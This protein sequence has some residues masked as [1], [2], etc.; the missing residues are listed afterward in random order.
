MN[1]CQSNRK[2]RMK[3]CE[4]HGVFSLHD[5][6]HNCA[7]STLPVVERVDRLRG[8]KTKRKTVKVGAGK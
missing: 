5:Y 3:F 2:Y 8:Q 7:N 1:K 6:P 4:K